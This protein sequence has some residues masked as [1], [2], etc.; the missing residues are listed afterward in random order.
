MK[1]Y[2]GIERRRYVRIPDKDLLSREPFSLKGFDEKGFYKKYAS[3]RDMSEGGVLFTSD[4]CFAIGTFL[5]L[6]I[7]VPGWEE[8]KVGFYQEKDLLL[9]EPFTVIGKVVRVELVGRE[10]YDVGISFVAVDSGHQAALKK[11]IKRSLEKMQ[12]ERRP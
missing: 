6:E 11:Y 1:K 3:T 9:H 12:K 5:K 2:S 8:L 7:D 10:R 4:I